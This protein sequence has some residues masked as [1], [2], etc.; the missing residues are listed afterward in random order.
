MNYKEFLDEVKRNILEFMPAEYE[1]AAVRLDGNMKNNNVVK[2]GISIHQTDEIITPILYLEEYFE[3]YEN[4]ASLES[5]FTSIANEYLKNTIKEPA[6][7]MESI[8]DY[9]KAKERITTKVVAVKHNKSLLSDRPFTKLDDLAV[10]Y[11]IELKN[12][13]LGQAT[14]PINHQMMERWGV[15]TNDIHELAINNTERS[16][17]STLMALESVLFGTEE[18]FLEPENSYE[19][20]SM[21][22]LTNENKLGGA[23]ALANSDIL[24]KV[25]QVIDDSFYILPSS[26]Q[27]VLVIPKE[28]AKERG[29]TP[30]MLGEMVREVNANEVS[31]EEQLSDHVYQFDKKTKSLETVKASIEKKKD[32]ER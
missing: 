24:S 19:R 29:M 26:V 9:E 1:T 18:N 15:T 6:F 11:Q 16:N 25:A 27:E 28:M 7:N 22:V 30:K 4:G 31:K 10:V 5:V 32:L 8:T 23:A 12:S 21:L 3:S 20:C 17:P 2:H 14:I 13:E